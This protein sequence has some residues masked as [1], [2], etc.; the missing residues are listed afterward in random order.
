[1]TE[2]YSEPIAGYRTWVMDDV[3]P[4]LTGVVHRLVWTPF[5]DSQAVC[6]K[7][8][9]ANGNVQKGKRRTRHKVPCL[10]CTCGF[11]A[12][13]SMHDLKLS[14]NYCWG[15]MMKSVRGVIIAYGRIQLTEKGFRAERARPVGLLRWNNRRSRPEDGIELSKKE[16]ERREHWNERLEKIGKV[17]RI[18]I[19]DTEK[20]LVEI[21]KEFGTP[22]S[23]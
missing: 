22:I 13:E 17:Y 4:V 1:M 11:W 16:M 7:N 20:E 18:P 15:S 6:R 8:I 23:H 12:Y 19:V 5:D 21:A 14:T 9:L 3:E 2:L 10:T